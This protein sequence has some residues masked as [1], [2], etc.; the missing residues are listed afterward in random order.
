MTARGEEKKAEVEREDEQGVEESGREAGRVGA[1]GSQRAS[2]SG[3]LNRG[4]G[5]MSPPIRV[6]S[7]TRHS[8]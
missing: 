6:R 2:R 3:L 7:D 4:T 1:S 8:P 5:L